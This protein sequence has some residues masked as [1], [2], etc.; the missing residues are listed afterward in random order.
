MKYR[1]I[2]QQRKSKFYQEKIN[3]KLEDI[4]WIQDV[5]GEWNDVKNALEEAAKESIGEKKERNEGWLDEECRKATQE[6]NIMR[7]IML[8]RMTGSSKKPTENIEGEEIKYAVKRK[9]RC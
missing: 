1:Q 2:K 4:D 6:K 5:Q 8:Q 3:A 7:K 9:E